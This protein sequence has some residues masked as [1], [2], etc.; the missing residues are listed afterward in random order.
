M[1]GS[2]FFRISLQISADEGEVLVDPDED[3]AAVQAVLEATAH[4]NEGFLVLRANRVE[5][6]RAVVAAAL[7]IGPDKGHRTGVFILVDESDSFGEQ[8][9][10]RVGIGAV[11]DGQEVA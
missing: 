11:F 4:D 3:A 9:C 1:D 2:E 7:P 5:K 8:G 6:F 10:N